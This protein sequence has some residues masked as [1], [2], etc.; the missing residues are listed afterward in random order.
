M[1]FLFDLEEFFS[2]P[3]GMPWAVLWRPAA[4]ACM[5][6]I[7]P[8][9]SNGL[10]PRTGWDSNLRPPASE[11]VRQVVPLTHYEQTAAESESIYYIKHVT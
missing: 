3:G 1:L 11:S 9:A 4:L 6:L 5:V 10:T 2:G 8:E 7:P